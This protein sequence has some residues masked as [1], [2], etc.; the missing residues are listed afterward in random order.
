MSLIV[1]LSFCQLTYLKKLHVQTWLNFLYVAHSHSLVLLWQKCNTLCV[2]S[3]L[4]ILWI[5]LYLL[6]IARQS[7]YG[8]C[9]KRLTG[10]E[11]GLQL[12]YGICSQWLTRGQQ[13][14]VKSDVC[15]CCVIMF[16]LF[17]KK[18]SWTCITDKNKKN[19]IQHNH[20]CTHR[21]PKLQTHHHT[22]T[23]M[24]KT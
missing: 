1:C 18:C 22:D 21:H 16:C 13:S 20:T 19:Q 5:T 15:D 12:W 17:R 6:I 2:L 3:F 10:C 9:W 4:W 24:E 7:N 8:I 11:Q 23:T 14:G